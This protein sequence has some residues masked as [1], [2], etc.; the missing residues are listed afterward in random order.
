MVCLQ[1]LETATREE[2]RGEGEAG[3]VLSETGRDTHH[4]ELPLLAV[5]WRSHFNDLVCTL[6]DRFTLSIIQCPLN[7]YGFVR[8]EIPFFL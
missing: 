2:V 7:L 4:A 8:F 6:W 1:V 5:V 3:S